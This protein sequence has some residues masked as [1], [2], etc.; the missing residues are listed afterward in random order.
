VVTLPV[1]GAF[2]NNASVTSADNTP[3][4]VDAQPQNTTAVAAADLQMNITTPTTGASVV[5]GASYQYI[6]SIT[7]NGPDP[8]E[9]G[10]QIKVAFDVPIGASITG[11]TGSGWSCSPS[12]GYPLSSGT[13]TCTAAA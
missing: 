8:V 12:T 11:F 10:G 9:S 13:I 5:A 1:S 3:N 7:N 2:T 4:T 6:T